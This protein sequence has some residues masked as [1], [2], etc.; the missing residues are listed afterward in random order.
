MGRP[1]RHGHDAAWY[2]EARQKQ[3]PRHGTPTSYLHGRHGGT[4]CGVPVPARRP[5]ETVV[6]ASVSWGEGES[7]ATASRG[8]GRG[9]T[10][11]AVASRRGGRWREG[12]ATG[13]GGQQGRIKEHNNR[14]GNTGRDARDDQTRLLRA[15]DGHQGRREAC[16]AGKLPVRE[17]EGAWWHAAASWGQEDGCRLGES[18]LGVDD[19]IIMGQLRGSQ[20]QHAWA[21]QSRGRSRPC[22]AMLGPG[23]NFVLWV[24]S[25][26]SG[27]MSINNTFP[28][29]TCSLSF[30]GIIGLV[31][32]IVGHQPIN[33]HTRSLPASA[34]ALF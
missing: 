18:E 34:H 29:A 17:E 15:G 14:V 26:A 12:C 25:W 32:L 27:H 3:P 19:R 13:G 20:A 23:Q 21:M 31:V 4:T 1:A 30:Y 16:D 28:C 11:T 2:D 9:R 7:I 6:L 5:E 8:R 24:S 10:T 22:R 33:N